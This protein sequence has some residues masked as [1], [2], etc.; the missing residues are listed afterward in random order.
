LGGITH[1]NVGKI[2]HLYH[3]AKKL[4]Q[5]TFIPIPLLPTHTIIKKNMMK[6]IK[7]KEGMTTIYL[8][9]AWLGSPCNRRKE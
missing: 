9:K 6:P 3:Y 1:T 7:N 5:N 2:T 8:V 4:S